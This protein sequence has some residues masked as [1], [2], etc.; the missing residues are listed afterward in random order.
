MLRF[1]T[2]AETSTPL[3]LVPCSPSKPCPQSRTCAR[4]DK[5]LCDPGK[6][7]IDAMVL[8]HR[9]GSWCPMFVDARGAALEAA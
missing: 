3:H 2:T 7:A 8:R 5:A 6:R 9:G 1:S 4:C